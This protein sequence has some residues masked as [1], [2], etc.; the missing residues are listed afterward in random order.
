MFYEFWMLNRR[1]VPVGK[2]S[3]ITLKARYEQRRISE[4]RRQGTLKLQCVSAEGLL[5]N[6]EIAPWDGWDN[7]PYTLDSADAD[8]IRWEV[9]PAFEGELCYRLVVESAARTEVVAEWGLY[10]LEAD[11]YPLLPL[12]GDLH[13]HTS[14][15]VAASAPLGSY[16]LWRSL[17]KNLAMACQ[18]PAAALLL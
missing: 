17:S 9:T 2:T 18:K 8:L 3:E 11:L 12:R 13:I 16:W 4:L 14:C 5:E 15:S 6:G 10:A 7:I 1:L